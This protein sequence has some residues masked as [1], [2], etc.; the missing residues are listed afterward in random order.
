MPVIMLLLSLSLLFSE[1]VKD[2][3]LAEI[4]HHIFGDSAPTQETKPSH[5]NV[6]HHKY[7]SP[8][9]SSLR[10]P[11]YMIIHNE[12]VCPQCYSDVRFVRSDG[13]VLWHNKY[14]HHAVISWAPLISHSECHGAVIKVWELKHTT[15]LEKVS[16]PSSSSLNSQRT[17]RS[18][19]ISDEV[20]SVE[21]E[22]THLDRDSDGEIEF[23][24]AFSSSNSS[25]YFPVKYSSDRHAN[26][27]EEHINQVKEDYS[28][29]QSSTTEESPR[30]RRNFYRS[31]SE[32]SQ[33]H[34]TVYRHHGKQLAGS[35]EGHI[36]RSENSVSSQEHFFHGTDKEYNS[37]DTYHHMKEEL[38]TST[39]PSVFSTI[40]RTAFS[41][42]LAPPG[43]Q[44]Q[45]IHERL[46]LLK[47]NGSGWYEETLSSLGLGI[48]QLCKTEHTCIPDI[49]SHSR[50]GELA[51]PYTV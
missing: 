5:E 44:L 34:P 42:T 45:Q 24:I 12:G 31:S 35:R 21:T 19:L 20:E 37:H 48:T 43:Y 16:Q 36:Q 26:L 32:L 47:N 22:P 7:L 15:V 3:H 51:I 2:I 11:C 1:Q 28:D 49:A 4:L 9:Q 10:D 41:T 39:L 38:A 25:D 33:D 6:E 29:V 46:G 27:N 17:T 23:N 8:G 30:A 50:S 13:H 40:S 14:Q 18:S